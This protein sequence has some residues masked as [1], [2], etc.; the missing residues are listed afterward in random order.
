MPAIV[1]LFGIFILLT[2]VIMSIHTPLFS[3]LPL[4]LNSFFKRLFYLP[5]H[6]HIFIQISFFK[7]VQDKKRTTAVKGFRI[8]ISA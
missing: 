6:W 4:F 2:D 3:E 5:L 1:A 7:D 8:N